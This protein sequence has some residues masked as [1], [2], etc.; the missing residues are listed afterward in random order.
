MYL[1]QCQWQ[2]NLVTRCSCWKQHF[3][4]RL[5]IYPVIIDITSSEMSS[6]TM[7]HSLTYN[8]GLKIDIFFIDF[9]YNYA[10]Y[11]DTVVFWFKHLGTIIFPWLPI[12]R[13]QWFLSIRTTG[14]GS[15]QSPR[16]EHR[17]NRSVWLQLKHRKKEKN[18][19]YLN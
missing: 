2:L 13:N 9:L 16:Y 11:V 7:C 18:G 6:V 8:F 19:A 4:C 10:A 15:P 12:T 3:R 17:W 14:N 1:L 5:I